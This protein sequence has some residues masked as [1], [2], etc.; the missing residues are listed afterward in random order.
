MYFLNF[1]YF[2]ARIVISALTKLKS[3]EQWGKKYLYEL[4]E[5]F[6][7][8][9]D[10]AVVEKVAKYQSIQ[11]HFVANNFSKLNGRLN[12]EIEKERNILFFLMSVLYDEIID[13][14][15]MNEDALDLL[16]NHP[17]NAK[18]ANFN[19]QILVYIH[20]R[21]LNEVDDK[22]SYWE[23]LKN[24]HQAQKDSKKQFD[25]TT[26]IDAIIDITKR[27]GGY[28]LL[29][30]R[31]Y[32]DEPSNKNMDECWYILGGLIQMTNDLYDTY[33]DTLNGINTFA[34]KIK[35]IEV[36][37]SIYQEQAVLL[38]EKINLLPFNNKKKMEFAIN[39]SII[40]AFGH[41]AINQLKQLQSNSNTLPNFNEVNRK[42]LIIDMEKNINIIRLIRYSYKF[43]KLW[44]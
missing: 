41:I 9:F 43:G 26:P 12:N 1:I 25:A 13:D 21:L 3:T 16:F 39:M 8:Q 20:Q 19:E 5:K 38:F 28:T 29:M 7:G 35:T 42:A 23:S 15:K 14:Q 40:P 6:G 27:K 18:P 30:C 36:I 22:K 33:K 17:E 10:N 24:T 4:E 32:I 37:N 31:H 44:M 34:T 2:I 11:L